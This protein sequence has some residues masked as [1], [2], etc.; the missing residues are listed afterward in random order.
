MQ[1]RRQREREQPWQVQ[2]RAAGKILSV[3]LS[4]SLFCLRSYSRKEQKYFPETASVRCERAEVRSNGGETV[5]VNACVMLEKKGMKETGPLF[6]NVLNS[7]SLS[8]E[9]R[10]TCDGINKTRLVI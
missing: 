9:L 2:N 6:K 5:E 7:S 4:R 8:D 3:S 1:E 10:P